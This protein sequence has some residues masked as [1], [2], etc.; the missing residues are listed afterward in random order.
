[1]KGVE[2]RKEHKSKHVRHPIA[3]PLVAT[4]RGLCYVYVTVRSLWTQHEA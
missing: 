3:A 2:S 4:P 1:M